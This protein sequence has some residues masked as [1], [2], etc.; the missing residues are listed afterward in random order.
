M[1]TPP[2]RVPFGAAPSLTW[3]D[4]LIGALDQGLRAF[5]APAA[6]TRPSPA[7]GLLDSELT[8]EERRESAALMRVNHAGEIA[9]QALYTGQALLARN[10]S[11]RNLLETAAREERDHLAWCAERITELGGRPSALDP[12]WYAGSFVIGMLAATRSDSTSLGFVR[13]TERQVEAHLRD[14]LERLPARDR[15]SSAILQQMAADEAHHGTTASLAGGADLPEPI[16]RCMS[17]G[18]EVLRRVALR[19]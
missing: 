3:A 5:A 16:R 7:A 18:G 15:K 12:L 17:F 13:E 8:A 4:R 10:E 1:P 11:T 19:V 6:A 14:H 2:P 9:A